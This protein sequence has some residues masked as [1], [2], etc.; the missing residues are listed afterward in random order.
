MIFINTNVDKKV[1]VITIHTSDILCTRCVF[2]IFS[3]MYLLVRCILCILCT[4]LYS[5]QLEVLVV[6]RSMVEMFTKCFWKHIIL[7][8]LKS[9]FCIYEIFSSSE[10]TIIVK[11]KS[12]II[13]WMMLI[14]QSKNIPVINADVIFTVA[15]TR[16]KILLLLKFL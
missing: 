2:Y 12:V 16:Q 13:F 1:Y 11:N 14:L 5:F 3:S 9:V 15:T 4:R 8:A 6:L 7:Y 10:M